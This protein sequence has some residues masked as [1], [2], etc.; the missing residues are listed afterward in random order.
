MHKT[1]ALLALTLG[2]S[3]AAAQNN[4]P[5]PDIVTDFSGPAQLQ[6]GKGAFWTLSLRNDGVAAAGQTRGY[7]NLPSS[8]S[9]D[10]QRGSNGSWVLNLPPGCSWNSN[11]RVLACVWPGIAVGETKTVHLPLRVSN[12]SQTLTLTGRAQVLQGVAES[13]TQNNNDPAVTQVAN[14]T[15]SISFP[16]AASLYLCMGRDDLLECGTTYG[17]PVAPEPLPLDAG[18]QMVFPDGTLVALPQGPGA[19]RVELYSGGALV[20]TWNLGAY[21]SRCYQGPASYPGLGA[22]YEA[23]ICY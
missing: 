10:L 15:P 19:L 23:R 21:D 16:A 3:L 9:P 18:G 14:Y 17:L 7:I 1:L 8:V 2:T 5:R 6:R 12:T 20:S 13:S 22:T 11:T 4:T